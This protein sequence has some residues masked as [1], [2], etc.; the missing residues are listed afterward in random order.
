MTDIDRACSTMT[1]KIRHLEE[2]WYWQLF[3]VLVAG[4]N[5]NVVAGVTGRFESGSWYGRH[6]P[7][8]L[9]VRV[10]VSLTEHRVKWPRWSLKYRV[11]R[12][13]QCVLKLTESEAET[14]KTSDRMGY[15]SDPTSL[16]ILDLSQISWVTSL[17]LKLLPCIP[18]LW[19]ASTESVK[20]TEKMML[21]IRWLH[22]M[23]AKAH[24]YN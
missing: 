4:K 14:T 7:E 24:L 20:Q 17:F 22:Q 3:A 5:V 21:A 13:N 2:K 15:L 6:H 1:R 10:S 18:C 19:K 12:R 16:N 11:D 9:V 23:D 8:L